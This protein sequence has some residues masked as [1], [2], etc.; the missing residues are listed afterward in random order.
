MP[1]APASSLKPSNAASLNLTTRVLATLLV[2]AAFWLLETRFPVNDFFRASALASALFM[3]LVL[4][5][6]LADLV[7]IALLVAPA[8]V[9]RFWLWHASV[10][11]PAGYYGTPAGVISVMAAMG[12][13]T[14]LVAALRLIWSK[15]HEER[16]ATLDV[17]GATAIL[18]VGLICKQYSLDFAA[19][20]QPKVLDLYTLS[21]DGSLG[22]QPSFA[23]GVLLDHHGWLKIAAWMAYNGIL[24]AMALAHSVQVKREGPGGNRF[25]ILLGFLAIAVAG[26]AIYHLFPAVGP[27]YAF[28]DFFPAHPLPMSVMSRVHLAPFFLDPNFPRNAVPSLHFSWVLFMWW[29][30]RRYGR[31]LEAASLIF[32]ALTILGT[33]GLGEHYL[34]DLVISFPFTLLI[35]AGMTQA[36]MDRGLPWRSGARLAALGFGAGCTA[37]WIL[38][39]RYGVSLMW[40]TPVVPWAAIAFTLVA[41]LYL[42]RLVL[43]S[44]GHS[45]HPKELQPTT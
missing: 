25:G 43:R 16:A 23:V 42:L 20:W 12:F 38:L 14:L 41:S 31:S 5:P 1:D 33:L 4:A 24:I 36:G 17:I 11:A 6:R 34:V 45:P 37:A 28:P 13:A 19:H 39:L 30:L 9:L 32:V 2:L 10:H 35:F 8:T 22:F 7:A 15:R 27:I 40:T 18:V 44:E 26:S 29:N 3:L 21:F